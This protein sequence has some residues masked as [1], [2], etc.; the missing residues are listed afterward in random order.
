MFS[1]CRWLQA[2]VLSAGLFCAVDGRA[3]GDWDACKIMLKSDVEAAFA[4][5]K[6]DAGSP[7]TAT[8]GTAKVAA[9]SSCTYNTIGT[10]AKDMV[11]VTLLA[12]RAPTDATGTTP[13]QARSGAAQLKATPVDVSGLGE[14][15]YWVN[16]GSASRPS[17]QLN[18][19]RGK[20]DWLI[21]GAGGK[22]D[23]ATA[24]ASLTGI[25]KAT[26]TR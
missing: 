22:M 15:A 26:S 19:F 25:A 1:R 6:F 10:S 21:F 16:Y 20:R 8:K 5:R 23:D 12:R 18:V 4:P 14:G 17:I 24:L 7:E 13:A 2:G 11:S 3:A 9:V